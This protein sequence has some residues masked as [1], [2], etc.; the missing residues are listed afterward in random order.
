FL[1]GKTRRAI[2]LLSDQRFVDLAANLNYFAQR[3]D[4]ILAD[5]DK[6]RDTMASVRGTPFRR[7]ERLYYQY[8]GGQRDKVQPMLGRRAADRWGDGARRN[9]RRWLALR[10]S[11]CSLLTAIPSPIAH[12]THCRRPFGAR[13]ISRRARSSASRTC[14]SG[15]TRPSGRAPCSSAGT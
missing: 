12:I 15:C 11:L 7:V 4:A 9:S 3:Y 2:D 13:A 6:R 14:C 8:I 10:S 1:M 5:Y